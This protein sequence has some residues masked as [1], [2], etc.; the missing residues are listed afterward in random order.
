[1]KGKRRYIFDIPVGI[2]HRSYL[3][4][5][6]RSRAFLFERAKRNQKLFVPLRWPC[7]TI[8]PAPRKTLQDWKKFRSLKDGLRIL[9]L[10]LFPLHRPSVFSLSCRHCNGT[11]PVLLRISISA[12][13]QAIASNACRISFFQNFR[14]I[15]TQALNVALAGRGM[16]EEALA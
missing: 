10:G 4:A 3:S 14:T 2:V 1:M 15:R 13:K 7:R 6:S 16:Q 12:N 9:F 11:E 5:P 8:R